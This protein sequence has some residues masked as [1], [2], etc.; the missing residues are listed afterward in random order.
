MVV[1]LKMKK[2]ISYAIWGNKKVYNQGIFYNIEDSKIY[3]PDWTCRVYC[4][5]DSPCLEQLKKSNCEVIV[6]DPI[7][8]K[9][10]YA[11]NN[12][13]QRYYAAADENASH[14]IFRDADSR[15]NFRESAAVQKWIDS[16]KALH[17]MHDYPSHFNFPICGG[18]WGVKGGWLLK[19]K[20]MIDYWCLNAGSLAAYEKNSLDEYFL[21][22]V[23]WPMF[24]Y[25]NYI[26]HGV[27][28]KISLLEDKNQPETGFAW[29]NN[30]QP[31]PDHLPLKK[32]TFVGQKI[33]DIPLFSFKLKNE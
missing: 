11:W 17:V 10:Q 7:Q 20:E 13:F 24:Q 32:G 25:G 27:F 29:G 31:F 19:I 9:T 6:F 21:K 15:L 23:V 3:Y 2:L 26:G 8:K 22:E 1:L 16:N 33:F 12:L 30:D 28:K 5:V 4:S 18:L 14:I